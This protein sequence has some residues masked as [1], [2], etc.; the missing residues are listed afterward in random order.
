MKE[1]FDVRKA[2]RDTNDNNR[3]IEELLER[4]KDPLVA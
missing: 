1:R 3:G 4:E 2:F